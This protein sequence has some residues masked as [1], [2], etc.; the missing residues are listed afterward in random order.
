MIVKN[1]EKVLEKCL[2]SVQSKVDEIIIVDTGSTDRT[3]EI[4]EKYQAKIYSFEWINDFA[5][6]RNYSLEQ[7]T[8]D[9]VLVLDADEYLEEKSDLKKDIANYKDYYIMRIKNLLSNNRVLTHSSIRIF[10]SEKTLRYKN[11]L[12]EH[13]DINQ[14]ENELS[15]G[16]A[17]AIIQHTGYKDEVLEEKDKR[18][19]NMSLMKIEVKENPTSYNLYNMAKIHMNIEEYKDAI[20]YFKKAF[21]GSDNR[22]YQPELLTRLANCLGKTG[23]LNE[24][25][26]ILDDGILIHPNDTDMWQERGD[27]YKQAGHY[28]EAERCWLKCLELGDQGITVNE[29]AGS[30]IAY[31]KLASL[32]Q[33]RGLLMESYDLI[34][35][36]IHLKKN[37]LPSLEKYF[38]IV[39]KANIELEDIYKNLQDIYKIENTQDLKVLLDV[40]YAL[41]HPLLYRYIKDYNLNLEEQTIAVA[42]QYAG[43][44]EEAKD[45]WIDINNID[46][47]NATD[48]LLLSFILQDNQLFNI[49]KMKLN[50]RDKEFKE[51]KKIIFAEENFL[52]AKYTNEFEKL[53]LS[54]AT[55]LIV[56]KEFDTFQKVSKIILLGSRE[57]IIEL[58]KILYQYQFDQVAIDVLLPLYEEKHQDSDVLK[59]LGDISLRAHQLEDAKFFYKKGIDIFQKYEFYERYYNLLEAIGDK[60]N[61]ELL[62]AKMRELFPSFN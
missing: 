62:K 26:K 44:Y 47:K 7:A 43:I 60:F 40:L 61:Q 35:N 54:I 50:F 15:R 27:L 23:E 36:S 13:L 25:L 58:S 2:S 42:K 59:L 24:G 52:G 20:E 46:E 19:R 10:K 30:Y 9:Y 53:L 16:E 38:S 29:G 12:H 28:N 31:Y 37:F 3:L 57:L 8:S 17:E 56:L 21:V 45:M 49:A 18:N 32:K 33:D 11:R 4:A 22:M 5:A 55:K 39:T 6:A 41:R 14:L 34:L 48:V 51:L 1:E